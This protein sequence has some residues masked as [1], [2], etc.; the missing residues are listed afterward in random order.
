M[1]LAYF[2][3][4]LIIKFSKNVNDVLTEKEMVKYKIDPN[5][6]TI[7]KKEVNDIFKD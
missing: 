1:I 2:S 5:I 6:S 3:V 4:Y 7:T